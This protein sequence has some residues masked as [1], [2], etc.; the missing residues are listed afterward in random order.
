M[1]SAS[2]KDELKYFQKFGIRDGVRVGLIR[3]QEVFVERLKYVLPDVELA[4]AEPGTCDV[5]LWWLHEK[6]LPCLLTRINIMKVKIPPTG[7]MWLIIPK[8]EVQKKQGISLPWSDIHRQV[9]TT[10]FV[11]NKVASVDEDTYG[12]QFVIRKEQRPV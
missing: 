2:N 9:L 5:I 8:K 6:D 10:T 12:T 3:P 4:I 7:K 11:D 1:V